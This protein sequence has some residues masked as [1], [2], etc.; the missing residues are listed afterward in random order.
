MDLAV[1]GNSDAE[2]PA[3]WI[4][5]RNRLKLYPDATDR[6]RP[7]GTNIVAENVHAF[8]A[9]LRELSLEGPRLAGPLGRPTGPIC[10]RADGRRNDGN[11]SGRPSMCAVPSLRRR[12]HSGHRRLGRVR[13]ETVFL[14]AS[15]TKN[16]AI[17]DIAQATA[18]ALPR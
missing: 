4:P 15:M 17:S 7:E 9:K 12:R 14:S 6:L 5:D 18:A 16:T 3:S 2:Q 11:V 8:S 10:Q 1:S 13:T